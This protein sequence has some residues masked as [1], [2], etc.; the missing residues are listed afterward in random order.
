VGSTDRDEQCGDTLEVC[1]D[2][3]S[4]KLASKEEKKEKFERFAAW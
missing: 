1:P 3:E 2:D 4:K